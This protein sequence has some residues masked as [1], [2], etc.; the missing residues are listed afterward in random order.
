M[1]HTQNHAQ[2]KCQNMFKAHFKLKRE[3]NKTLRFTFAHYNYFLGYQ[4]RIETPGAY[5][6]S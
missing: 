2:S 3:K 6:N 1:L 4:S 5:M